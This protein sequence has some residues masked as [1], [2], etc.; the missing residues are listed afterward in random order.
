MAQALTST[1]GART[2]GKA[3]NIILWILQLG[4]AFMF[5]MSG[6]AK[7]SSAPQMV[8]LFQLIGVGQWFR[9]VTGALE[10]LGAVALL[11]P[12]FAGLGALLLVGVMV[13]AVLTHLLVIGGSPLMAVVLLL[14]SAAIAW[15]RCGTWL[16]LL[17]R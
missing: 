9:Y 2:T 1:P 11:V 4:A 3:A 14:V 6:Y 16:R 8:G 10:V 7:L 5:L 17:G 13:G 12:R 15:G